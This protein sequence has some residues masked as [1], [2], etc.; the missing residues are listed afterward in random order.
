[1]ERIVTASLEILDER[2]PEGVTVQAVVERARSSVGSFYARFGGKDDLLEYLGRRVWDEA[3]E[4]WNV[5]TAA[6]PWSEM[7]LAE[8]VRDAVGLLVD[9]RRSRVRQ[10]RAL[11][12]TAGATGAYEAFRER[13]LQ[14]LEGLL[15]RRREEVTHPDPEL[16]VRLGLRA[17]LGLADSELILDGGEVLAR[18][19]LLEECSALLMCYLTGAS[20]GGSGG[21][22]DFFDVW[23]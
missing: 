14:D 4:R 11:D 17:V 1:L 7:Q 18:D 22:V 15:L 8:M 21:S 19:V 6:R 3:L 16:A 13:L 23:G 9:L 12:R 5:A 10:L 20:A 2:G